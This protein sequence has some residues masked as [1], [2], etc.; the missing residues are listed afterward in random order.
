M[1]DYRFLEVRGTMDATS[2]K[3]SDIREEIEFARAVTAVIL[4]VKLDQSEEK[5]QEAYNSII[6]G[7]PQAART[8]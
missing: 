6:D 1:R 2:E 4:A 8:Q 5:A 3:D 7:A